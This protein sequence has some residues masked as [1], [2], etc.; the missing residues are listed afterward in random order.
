MVTIQAET[1]YEIVRKIADGGMGSVYEALQDGAAGFKKTVALKTMLPKL[2]EHKRYVEMFIQEANLVANLVH[3]NIV[4]IYQFGKMDHGYYIVMEYVNGL[5]LDEFL[6]YHMRNNVQ[7]PADLAIFIASRIARA[8]EYAHSRTDVYGNP[9]EII[10]RDVSPKN[11]MI[12]TE[13]LPKLTDF[14]LAITGVK[15]LGVNMFAGKLPYMSPEQVKVSKV[16]FRTDIF[17]LGAVLFELLS[18]KK[19]RSSQKKSV[20]MPQ[21]QKGTVEWDS[22][23][24]G[25]SPEVRKMLETCMAFKPGDRSETTQTLAHELELLIYRHGYGPTIKTLEQY[26]RQHFPTLYEFVSVQGG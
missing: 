25:V 10:H 12:T 26:L 14:G 18:L 2:T 8:L 9:L 22:L 19:I 6:T 15:E 20:H 13:G 17:S 1:N 4:Q 11:V 3:E 16:D 7:I 21:A 24:E 23:P 5:S